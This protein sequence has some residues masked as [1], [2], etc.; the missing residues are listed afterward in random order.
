MVN[1][2]ILLIAH[3]CISSSDCYVAT[4]H[5]LNTSSYLIRLTINDSSDSSG[6]VDRVNVFRFSF[7]IF[8]FFGCFCFMGS[9]WCV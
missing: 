2:E 5:L 7:G 3:A 6:F 8:Y 9:V 4:D 1:D